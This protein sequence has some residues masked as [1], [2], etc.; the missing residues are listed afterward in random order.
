M[1]INRHTELV[2]YDSILGM[3]VRMISTPESWTLPPP[4]K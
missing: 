4:P 3:L 2:N 1:R